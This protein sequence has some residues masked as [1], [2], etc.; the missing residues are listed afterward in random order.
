[1]RY[2]LLFVL[3]LVLWVPGAAVLQ[4][5]IDGD[6]RIVLSTSPVIINGP[7]HLEI[8]VQDINTGKTVGGLEVK[9]L[10]VHLEGHSGE[11]HT[12]EEKSIL[13]IH[14]DIFHRALVELKP[15]PEDPQGHYHLNY[16]FDE[17]GLYEV[18]LQIENNGD[19]VFS[20]FSLDAELPERE[21]VLIKYS[22]FSIIG[23]SFIV[24]AAL[25][26]AL[27]KIVKILDIK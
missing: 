9:G 24:I 18:V 21:P 8:H 1:M 11:P 7:V 15:N 12:H 20:T 27:R 26:M 14:N 10:I 5:N 19:A 13:D 6:Y 4:T 3:P 17:P 25:I 22:I 23:A 16:F 2:L